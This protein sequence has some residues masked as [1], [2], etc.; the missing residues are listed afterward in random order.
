M[1]LPSPGQAQVQA[2]TVDQVRKLVKQFGRSD[3]RDVRD[4]VIVPLFLDSGLRLSELADLT[5]DRR[6][7]TNGTCAVVGKCAKPRV[8]PFGNATARAIDRYLRPRAKHPG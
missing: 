5:L 4:E 6:D 3:F 2:L 7:I 8:V 1:P